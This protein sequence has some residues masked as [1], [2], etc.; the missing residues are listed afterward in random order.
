MVGWVEFDGFVILWPKPNPTRYKKG[1]VTQPNPPSLKNRPN[2][3]GWV[4]LGRVWQVGG[5]S[6]HSYT[7][8]FNTLALPF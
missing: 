8:V 6:A 1:F 3:E 2:P 7:Q 5:F 4:R